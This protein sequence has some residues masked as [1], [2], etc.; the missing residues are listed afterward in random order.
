[1]W[2]FTP[3]WKSK[4]EVKRIQG[5]EK[6]NPLNP[7]HQQIIAEIA[8]KDGSVFVR[9]AAADRLTDQDVLADV[10]KND[11]E[12]DVCAIA[13][14]H[15]T[16][17]NGLADVARNS[18]ISYARKTAVQKI[19]DQNILI[20]LAITDIDYD[21]QN[22]AINMI[23]NNAALSEIAKSISPANIKAIEKIDNWDQNV[24][25]DVAK[26]AKVYEVRKEAYVKQNN[27]PEIFRKYFQRSRK[28][29]NQI[30]GR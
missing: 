23:L 19:T 11:K 13:L 2:P 16:D 8:K 29:F 17:Q 12:K 15:L 20:E 1:M 10:A 5:V 9:K 18:K 4:D 14:K 3:K 24:L 25:K 6:L 21:V 26:N 7:I 30:N 22:A 27:G 28:I